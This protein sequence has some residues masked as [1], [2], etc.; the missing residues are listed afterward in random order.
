MPLGAK[1]TSAELVVNVIN[2]SN[3]AMQMSLYRMQ[4]DWSESTATWNS[5]GQIGGVQASEGESS[6]LPPDAVLFD[7]DTSA[8]SPT[9]GIFDV[10]RSLEYWAAQGEASNFGWLIESAATNGWDFDT[11]EAAVSDRPRLTVEFETPVTNEFQILSTDLVAGRG[12]G[13]TNTHGVH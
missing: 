1:I 12:A 10:T 4:Q 3:S 9:A 2:D 7:P 11:K 6:D 13:R 8:N 5:F